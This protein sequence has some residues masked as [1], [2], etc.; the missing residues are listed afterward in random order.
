MYTLANDALTVSV[1]DPLADQARFGTRYCTGGYIFQ[2]DDAQ[3]GPLLT[4]PNYPDYPDG[5]IPYNGQGLPDAFNLSPLAEPKPGGPLALIVGIGLCDLVEDR[6]V[7]FCQWEAEQ[8]PGALRLR[9]EQVFQGFALQLER[10]VTLAGRTV[11]SA[12]RLANTGQG[13]IPICWFPHP[14]YPQPPGDELCRFNVPVGMPANPGYTLA[15]N[16]F[17]ARR[18]WPDGRGFYQPLDMVAHTPL[19]VLQKHP[20]LGLVAG[21]CSYV[22]TFMPIWGNA[23]TFSWEPYFERTLAMG[24][25]AEWW[26]DYDF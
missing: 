21:T 16:G 6:V 7:D 26:I 10:T 19:V 8:T 18:Q 11:R 13:F 12:T 25:T 4:G 14:F 9:T 5:F 15:P 3:R 1:L 23:N 2:I 22:P 20:A 17:V 24:Q